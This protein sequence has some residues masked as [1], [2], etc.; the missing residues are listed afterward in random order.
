M[1]TTTVEEEARR[2]VEQLPDDATWEDLQIPNRFPASGASRSERLPR[3]AMV[4]LAEAKRQF[5]YEPPLDSR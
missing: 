1:S 4:P 3:R 5:L 2:L